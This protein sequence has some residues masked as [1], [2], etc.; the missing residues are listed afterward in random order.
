MMKKLITNKIKKLRS[1]TRGAM[2]V[3]YA[4][5]A[6]A[7]LAM[8]FGMIETGRILMVNSYLEGAVTE[9]T[10]ISLT[11]SVPDGYNSTEEYIRAYLN[12]TLDTVGIQNAATVRMKVYD[13]FKNIGEEEP[14]TDTNGDLEC[15]NGEFYTDVNANG[16]WDKDMGASGSG[17]EENIMLMEIEV[18]LPYLLQGFIPSFGGYGTPDFIT[19]EASTVVRNEPYGGVPWEPSSTVAACT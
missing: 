13:S 18:Q 8:T 11:G 17:G 5:I 4:L 2:A 1:N 19:L 15:N 7:F 3:E 6:P 12:S 10:R 14:Y 9:A 16:A